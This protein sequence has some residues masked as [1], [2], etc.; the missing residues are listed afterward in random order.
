MVKVDIQRTFHAIE[1]NVVIHHM[2]YTII[3]QILV[4]FNGE[5]VIEQNILTKM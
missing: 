1:M 3:M 5:N 4:F 2:L